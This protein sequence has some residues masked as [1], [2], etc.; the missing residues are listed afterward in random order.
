MCVH[1]CKYIRVY[2]W[3]VIDVSALHSLSLTLSGD[4]GVLMYIYILAV[5]MVYWLK[6]G[7]GGE[8]KAFKWGLPDDQI[9]QFNMLHV[10]AARQ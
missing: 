10:L 2:V 5:C 3:I 4:S 7:A 8:G 6:D 9:S 1:V